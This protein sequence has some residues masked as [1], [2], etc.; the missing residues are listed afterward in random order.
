MVWS[1]K[2]MMAPSDTA[3]EL[4]RPGVQSA[5]ENEGATA[6]SPTPLRPAVAT[7]EEA[8][9]WSGATFVAQGR[10]ATCPSC[11]LPVSNAAPEPDLV[12]GLVPARMGVPAIEMGAA[13]ADEP[14]LLA[15]AP[16]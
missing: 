7:A 16:V 9:A 3:D 4:D 11:V 15:V 5:K 2:W 1:P 8:E 13:D 10:T 6:T 14:T 12:V